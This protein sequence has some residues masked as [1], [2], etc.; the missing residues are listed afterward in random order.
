MSERDEAP[1][2]LRSACGTQWPKNP[3]HACISQIRMGTMQKVFCGAQHRQNSQTFATDT[4]SKK[5]NFTK[6]LTEKSICS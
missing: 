3:D 5:M 1:F 6:I 4:N 2:T